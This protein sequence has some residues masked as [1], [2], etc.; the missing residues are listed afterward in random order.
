MFTEKP[1]LERCK[2]FFFRLPNTFLMDT[3][4]PSLSSF[5]V[6]VFCSP[7]L[8]G[9]QCII[10]EQ[11]TNNLSFDYIRFVYV[12]HFR[13][14]ICFRKSLTL[15]R[16]LLVRWHWI[17]VLAHQTGQR[18]LR[19]LRRRRKNGWNCWRY[20]CAMTESRAPCVSLYHALQMTVFGA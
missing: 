16:C 4:H 17:C 15:M 2:W 18:L 10:H 7:S 12:D 9:F 19:K 3:E 5:H 6:P 14:L 8:L 11:I 1:L 20:D 13:F